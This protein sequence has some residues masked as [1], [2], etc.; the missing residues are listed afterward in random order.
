MNLNTSIGHFQREVSRLLN[1]STTAEET[2]YAPIRTLWAAILAQLNLPFEIR[3]NTKERR[4]GGPLNR[5]DIAFYDG[6][7]EYLVVPAEVKLPNAEIDDVIMSTGRNDQIGRYLAASRVLIATN[8]RSVSLV[9]VA[10]AFSGSGAVPPGSRVIVRTVDLWTSVTAVRSGRPISSEEAGYLVELLEAAVTQ[11][12][13]IAEPQSLARIFA[14]QAR[15]AKQDLPGEFSSAVRPLLEDFGKALGITFEGEKGEEFFRSALVQTAFYGV[16]S[17]WVLWHA[18]GA[19]GTFEWSRVPSYLRIPFLGNL[20]YEF[21]HPTR[22]KELKLAKHLDIATAALAR[23]DRG[24]FFNRFSIPDIEAEVLREGA[25]LTT[26]AITYFYEP[27]LAAFDPNLRKEL[28]VW[29][30]PWEIVRYQVRRVDR[31]L[32]DELG[33]ARGFADERVV[34]LDPACGTGAYLVEVL[35][36]IAWQLREEGQDALM[37]A[38]LLEAFTTRIFGFEILMAPFVIAL[39]QLYLVLDKLG[40]DLDAV[41]GQDVASGGPRLGV[42][43]TNAL[44]GWKAEQAIQLVFPELQAERDAAQNVKHHAKVI[45]I[46][47]NPPYDRFASAAVAEEGG[48]VDAYVGITRNAKG[49]QVGRTRLFDA[50]GV[51]KH[52]LNDLYIRFFRLAEKRIGEQAEFGIVSFISNSRFYVG[53]SH[54]IMR[55]SLLNNFDHIWIDNLHGY[56][57]ASERTPWGDSCETIFNVEG[58]GPG[59]KV[60]TGI[61]TLVKKRDS[62]PRPA[63]VSFR[64]FWGRAQAKRAALLE[65]LDLESWPS[66]RAKEAAE[67]PQGPRAYSTHQVSAANRW[68]LVGGDAPVGYEDWVSLAELFPRSYMGVH[69]GK[70]GAVTAFDEATLASRFQAYFLPSVSDAEMLTTCPELLD[71]ANEFEDPSAFRRASQE[72]KDQEAHSPSAHLKRYLYRP[73]DGRYIWYDT[74][75]RQFQAANGESRRWSGNLIQRFGEQFKADIGL[76][77]LFLCAVEDPRRVSE[78][79]PLL[80]TTLVDLH[81]HDRGTRVIPAWAVV[82]AEEPTLHSQG[83][84]ARVIPNLSSEVWRLLSRTWSLSG[85]VES[86]AACR[87]TEDLFYYGLAILHSPQYQIDNRA[88]LEQDW[89]RIPITRCARPFATIVEHGRKLSTLL[90]PWSSVQPVLREIL[91]DA[92]K[93]LAKPQHK[94]ASKIAAGNL[95]VTYS[96]YAAGKGKWQQRDPEV[97]ESSS[98]RWGTATGDL[99]LNEMVFL[100]NIPEGVWRYELGGYPVLKKWLGY[101]QGNRRRDAPLSLSEL[102]GFRERVHRVAAILSL[103]EVLD[104]AYEQASEDAFTIEELGV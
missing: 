102:A 89:A 46:I 67:R 73:L 62:G 60:G 92:V 86:Q 4:T 34:V 80:S 54:P 35:R 100:K 85:D 99:Y 103:H 20:F 17:G 44:T 18:E 33:C 41:F 87:M 1:S 98:I 77:N 63:L 8:I 55:E 21:Q 88:G 22:L 42:M 28:G 47:G 83:G 7:G 61:T 26:A 24:H 2:Y 40:A 70:D 50:W 13:S 23:V 79:V 39:L 58:G 37:P 91:G 51:K 30:T 31:L 29:Y 64:D 3:I 19:Q 65:S 52:L 72:D 71:V 57:I 84:P 76:E 104:A 74:K 82:A 14:R 69:T 94:Q 90:D 75:R 15:L 25:A 10:P 53:K 38:T 5:P 56:R 45:V 48:L 101:R 59:I 95:V 16:F 66:A 49:K 11:F 78:S 32:R 96:Y 43:L 81:L 12:A 27:F 6:G 68:R 36:C 93:D 97:A 9:T